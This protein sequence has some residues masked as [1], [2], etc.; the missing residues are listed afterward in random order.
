MR[1]EYC[2]K[3]KGEVKGINGRR[4]PNW[5]SGALRRLYLRM[6]DEGK[7]TTIKTNL[8]ICERCGSV[9]LDTPEKLVLTEV[10]DE[11]LIKQMKRYK[12]EKE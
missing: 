5:C 9:H 2:R 10:K 12:K 6:T 4:Y 11:G 8:L 7:A 3:D 1:K